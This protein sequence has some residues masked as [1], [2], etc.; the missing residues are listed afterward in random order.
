MIYRCSR[1]QLQDC[2]I[3]AFINTFPRQGIIAI[4]KLIITMPNRQ[5]F[6]QKN[7]SY[8]V[9]IVKI[10]S[11]FFCT[12]HHFTQPQ[13]PMLYSAFQSAI[14]SKSTPSCG[15]TSHI[16]HVPWTHLT[17]HNKLH[18]AQLTAEL[19]SWSLSSLFNTNM[20]ISE[21]EPSFSA[22]TLLVGS[23]DP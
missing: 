8:D 6:L 17:Q 4:K 22:L 3:N 20:A 9:Q 15:S 10:G 7:T 16:I 14:H 19:V 2:E 1:H 5:L 18:L 21:T 12:A 23:F 11:P 13:N